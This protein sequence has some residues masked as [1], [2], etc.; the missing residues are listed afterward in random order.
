L[1]EKHRKKL[2]KIGHKCL[3]ESFTT[4][5]AGKIGHKCLMQTFKTKKADHQGSV[6]KKFEKQQKLRSENK[7]II[8]AFCTFGVVCPVE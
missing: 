7:L 8:S 3:I 5:K 1:D 6:I 2:K 4:K